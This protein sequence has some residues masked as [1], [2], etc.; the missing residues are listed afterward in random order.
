MPEKRP[1]PFETLPCIKCGENR[2][3]IGLDLDDLITFQ[4]R[5]CENQ[6]TREEV[7]STVAIWGR[8][9]AWIDAAYPKEERPLKIG[10]KVKFIGKGVGCTGMHGTIY[11]VD[12]ISGR[13]AME[14]DKGLRTGLWSQETFEWEGGAA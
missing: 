13:A 5:E 2:G 10:D 1:S 3:C 12:S 9:L 6:F 4:C 7:E 8:C 11:E 14:T